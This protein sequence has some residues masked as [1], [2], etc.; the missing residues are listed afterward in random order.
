MEAEAGVERAAY[1]PLLVDQRAQSRVVGIWSV[2]LEAEC[3]RDEVNPHPQRLA[4]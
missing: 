1:S 3:G 2:F 4:Q